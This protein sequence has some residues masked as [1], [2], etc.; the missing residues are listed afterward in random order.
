MIDQPLVCAILL[1]ADRP[2]FVQTAIDC[3]KKQTYPN[4]RLFVYDTGAEAAIQ[5]EGILF[6]WVQNQ[7]LTVGQLRNCAIKASKSR[8]RIEA[9]IICHWDDDDW[10]S[11]HR[12][13]EQVALLQGSWADVVG[14]RD[15][16]FWQEPRSYRRLDSGDEILNLGAN[17]VIDFAKAYSTPGE[18]WLYTGTM[19]GTSLCYSRKVWEQHPFP[20]TSQ[21]EDTQWLIGLKQCAARSVGPFGPHG[22]PIEADAPRMI[23]RIHAGNT[24]TGYRPEHMEAAAEWKRIPQW[25]AYCSEVMG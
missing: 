1:T 2:Q 18:A 7:G 23:A 10:S 20:P 13:A 11:P 17:N 3:F 24:S 9:D 4:K 15:M 25:A 21:G 5:R 6:E 22:Q 12:M 16:L 14:Y 8:G 19:L